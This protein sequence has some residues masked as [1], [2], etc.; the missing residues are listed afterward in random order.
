MDNCEARKH[1]DPKMRYNRGNAVTKTTV[2]RLVDPWCMRH[3]LAGIP[4]RDSKHWKKGYT[5]RRRTFRALSAEAKKIL[6]EGVDPDGKK[7]NEY[8][9]IWAAWYLEENFNKYT[10]L[11]DDENYHEMTLDQQFRVA[12]ARDEAYWAE[13]ADAEERN[14]L[15]RS[16][17]SR[18]QGK[19]RKI[20]DHD[21]GH[22]DVTRDGDKATK[23]G[24][25]SSKKYNRSLRQN[26]PDGMQ[27]VMTGRADRHKVSRQLLNFFKKQNSQDES[28]KDKA[29]RGNL[30][31]FEGIDEDG[32]WIEPSIMEFREQTV[33]LTSRRQRMLHAQA[34]VGSR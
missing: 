27:A 12:A 30:S 22:V 16:R 23:T 9:R 15:K 1:E 10:C 4:I 2:D 11:G 18:G 14:P 33:T 7:P 29:L 13:N 19:R 32:E 5:D 24:A 20:S 26:D 28:G 21:D 31:A 25:Q 6:Y 17:K 3:A 34:N 8:Q